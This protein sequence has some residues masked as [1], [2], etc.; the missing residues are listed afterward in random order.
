[1]A[2]NIR[3]PEVDELATRLAKDRGVTKTQAVKEALL[4]ELQRR[5][6]KA[7]RWERLQPIVDRIAARPDTGV[8]IDKA[9]FDDLAGEDER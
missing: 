4:G 8:V 6:P 3:D 2:L 1:M 5:E 7:P 9:F